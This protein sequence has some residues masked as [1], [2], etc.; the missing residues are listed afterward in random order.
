MNSETNSGDAR[1]DCSRTNA[2]SLPRERRIQTMRYDTRRQINARVKLTDQRGRPRLHRRQV[3]LALAAFGVAAWY[4]LPIKASFL[5][6]VRYPGGYGPHFVAVGDFNGDSLA[7]FVTSVRACLRRIIGPQTP[8]CATR[9]TSEVP[10][11]E[12]A[13]GSSPTAQRGSCLTSPMPSCRPWQPGPGAR[14]WRTLISP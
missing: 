11:R 7:D 5:A 1:A 3:L 2:D 12:A 14:W 4:T 9:I 10:I 8:T 6:P 13:I